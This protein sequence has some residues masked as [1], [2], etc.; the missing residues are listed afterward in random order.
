VTVDLHETRLTSENA[1][2]LIPEYDLVADGTDNFPTRYLVNDACVLA[3]VPNVY[4]SIFRFEGQV[5]VF[6]APG[7]PD[8]R[9]LY[10]EPPPPGLV[11]SCAEGGVL[12]V[13]PGLVGTIQATE[14]I[15]MILDVGDPLVGRLLLIDALSM[16]F[17]TLKVRKD[18][19]NPIS[20]ENPTITELIDYEQFCGIPQ[21]NGN[22][23][24]DDAVPEVTVRTL[25][26]R[27]EAGNAPFLLDVRKPY[28]AEIADIGADQL[29][30][31]EELAERLAEIRADRNDEIVVHC[32]SGARSA[33]AVKLMRESGF[34]NVSNLAG[35]TLAWSEEIDDAVPTY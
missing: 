5:S 18:P 31:V 14:V 4:A 25:N 29:I 19:N 8:Y 10:P 21:Q 22:A 33:R 13:L 24:Q 3:G 2:D 16:S 32:R 26:A 28:E 15:K 30:P 23:Q 9:D 27:R 34:T 1:L 6:G 11:P 35:G 20:G 7:G 12:G 17:R